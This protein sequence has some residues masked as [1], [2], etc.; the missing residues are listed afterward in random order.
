MGDTNNNNVIT[1]GDDE[2]IEEEEETN[3]LIGSGEY[4]IV[5]IRYY[6]GVAHPGEFVKLVREPHNPYD[7]NA[8]RVD[9]M[10]DEKIGHI[11]ATMAKLLATILDQSRQLNVKIE[12]TIPR[13]GNAFNLPILL[14]FYSTAPTAIGAQEVATMLKKSLK[15]DYIFKLTREFGGGGSSTHASVSTHQQVVPTVI[16]K[17]MDWG[18]QQKQL[19][20]MFDK[21]LEDQ[22]KGLPDIEMP[23]HLLKGIKLF[24]YQVKG[25][26]WLVKKE[27]MASPAPFYKSVKEMGQNMYLCEITQS[28]QRDAPRPIQ[29]SI[30][31]DAMGLG[32]S[33]QTICLILSSPPKGVTYKVKELVDEGKTQEEEKEETIPMP[34]EYQIRSANTKVLKEILKAA[35]LKVSGKKDILIQ[36]ILDSKVSGEHF[37]KYMFVDPNTSSSSTSLKSRCTMIVCPVSVM[38]NWV[39]QV[40]SHVQDGVL[41]LQM[42]HGAN[43]SDILK[44]VKADMV[45]ILLVS[46][47]TLAADYSST[48]GDNTDDGEPKKKRAKTDTIFDTDFFRIV[49]DEAHTIRN[50]KTKFFKAVKEIK[51]EY[52]L[53]LTGTPFVNRADDVHS[54]LAF[55]SVEPLDNKSIFTRAI[56]NPIKNGDE[57]GL[58]RLRTCMSFLSL[59]RSKE[60]ANIKLVEKEVQLCSVEFLEDANKKTY[61]ALYGTLRVAM[62]AILSEGDGKQALKNYSSIFEKILRLRQACCTG[63]LVAKER[64]DIAIKVWDELNSRKSKE[65]LTA[66][67]GLKLLDKL[68]AEFKEVPECGICLME[69]EEADGIILKKCQHVFCKSCIKQVLSMS[70]KKCPYCRT[71][72]AEGEIIDMCTASD[73]AAKAKDEEQNK[74]QDTKDTTFGTSPKIK[75]LLEE[76]KKMKPDEKGVIFSQFT[77]YLDLIGESMKEAGH[78]FVRIDGSVSAQN[79]ITRIQDFNSDYYEDSPRFILCSL[80][81]SGTGIN[82]TRGNYA[83]MMDCWWNEAIESQAMDRIHRINQTRK[84]TVLRFVMKDSI[85]ER[86]IELQEKKSMQAKGVL[87]KLK[88]DE[89]RKALL[90][91]LRGLLDIPEH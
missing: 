35:K 86:I 5:G 37:P 33:I 39:E 18:A 3:I 20:E 84:V 91:D 14:E 15:R 4:L 85:E 51:S 79:R 69:M 62:E 56:T 25:V 57:I 87:Q 53:A 54:L 90:G 24:E 43:R 72:F 61:E 44:E 47:H 78:S 23:Y 38:G 8:I 83:F 75:A 89:K 80:L 6:K 11:K 34:P 30:L 1:I 49:L 2:G 46:Y 9:N 32:K 17:K 71:D 73:A 13:E 70:N 50:S 58:T 63:K 21:Q 81:A 48:F 65:K 64:R 45:D 26:K 40:K 28:S 36:R 22:Y 74:A 67:E 19:D 41:S 27:T 76:I 29:G 88:G 60:N 82:L 7:R 59:R 10:R 12:G 55:L 42:Y 31:C 77:S 66:E 52:K 16:R 68:K